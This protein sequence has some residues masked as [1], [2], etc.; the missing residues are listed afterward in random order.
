MGVTDYTQITKC[1]HPKGGVDIIMSKFDT[2]KKYNK[3][4]SKCTK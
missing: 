1:K 3:I 2:P 4:L